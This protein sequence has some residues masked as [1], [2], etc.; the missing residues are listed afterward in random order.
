MSM[1]WLLNHCFYFWA[2]PF[3]LETRILPQET[4]SS[5]NLFLCI[6]IRLFPLNLPE[7][8]LS[9]IV[10]RENLVV[11]D[12][13]RFVL[14]ATRE[15]R[16]VAEIGSICVILGP[17]AEWHCYSIRMLSSRIPREKWIS[18]GMHYLPFFIQFILNHLFPLHPMRCKPNFFLFHWDGFFFVLLLFLPLFLSYLFLSLSLSDPR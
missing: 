10:S 12:E 5:F 4:I 16:V 11:I 6:L 2:R 14:L 18:N 1:R 17:T 9:R 7:L 13:K 15:N 8:N 3:W